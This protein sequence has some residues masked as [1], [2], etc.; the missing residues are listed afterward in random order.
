MQHFVGIFPRMW[1]R[2]LLSGLLGSGFQLQLQISFLAMSLVSHNVSVVYQIE[3]IMAIAAAFAKSLQVGL[4][5]VEQQ[6]AQR[7]AN[8]ML[9][10]MMRLVQAEQARRHPNQTF[11]RIQG[12][13]K[14]FFGIGDTV[15]LEDSKEHKELTSLQKIALKAW[16][17]EKL[18]LIAALLFFGNLI[19]AICKIIAVYQCPDHLWNW[20]FPNP[21]D[22]CVDLSKFS[23]FKMPNYVRDMT[24][25]LYEP[26]CH[27]RGL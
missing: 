17:R 1:V 11:G 10:E 22:G 8:V 7:Q 20:K 15:L 6:R 12:L 4:S 25:G 18:L 24:C 14:R 27:K 3:A 9:G 26:C 13:K 2:V 16:C 21:L 5:I 23:C 19:W